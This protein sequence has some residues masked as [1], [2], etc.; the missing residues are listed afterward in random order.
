MNRDSDCSVDKS[1]FALFYIP[2]KGHSY[3]KKC[4]FAVNH[5][6]QGFSDYIST[7]QVTEYF[8][9]DQLRPKLCQSIASRSQLGDPL[10]K[11]RGCNCTE[12][13][14]AKCDWEYITILNPDYTT[15]T[16][17]KLSWS[18]KDGIG[19]RQEVTLEAKFKDGTRL[20]DK[21]NQSQ[22]DCNTE[23]GDKTT[24]PSTDSPPAM[25]SVKS[26]HKRANLMK[27][28]GLGIGVF[29]A[30]IFLIILWMGLSGMHKRRQEN[31]N[32]M[33]AENRNHSGNRAR[34]VPRESLQEE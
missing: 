19:C 3:E 25:T 16:D 11:G 34:Y 31:F 7:V 29:G 6:V 8:P 26:A 4:H 17:I 33:A 9:S 12:C 23:P 27:V 14:K 24:P 18:A 28:A 21:I 10:C 30:I 20:P 5:D 2:K 15:T 22:P 13:N 1:C 32:R